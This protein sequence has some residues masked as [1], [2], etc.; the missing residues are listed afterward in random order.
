MTLITQRTH[1]AT[2]FRFITIYVSDKTNF[3]C[4]SRRTLTRYLRDSL[5]GCICSHYVKHAGNEDADKQLHM[6]TRD[7]RMTV[8]TPHFYQTFSFLDVLQRYLAIQIAKF[9]EL[10]KFQHDKTQS[11]ALR[12]IIKLVVFELENITDKLNGIIF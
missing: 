10:F 5:F 4:I 2:L 3:Y 12:G 7:P 11:R 6:R 9:F 1:P 8:Q